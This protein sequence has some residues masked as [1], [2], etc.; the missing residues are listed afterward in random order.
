MQSAPFPKD[1]Q[2]GPISAVIHLSSSAPDTDIGAQLVDITPDGR[3]IAIQNGLSRVRFRDGY[4]TP[5]PLAPGEIAA[6]EVDLWSSA[7]EFD[8]GHRIGVLISS[9]QFPCM[10]A[11]RNLYDDL[12]RGTKTALATQT[13]HLGG[14]HAS[15]LVVHRLIEPVR[16]G[17]SNRR[18]PTAP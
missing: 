16:R 9:A 7:Y 2:V 13:V 17:S 10:D 1:A 3:L 15:K 5:A 8:T 4:D 11:H 6:I 14:S 12:S 18:T